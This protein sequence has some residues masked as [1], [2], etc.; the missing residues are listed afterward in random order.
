MR[1]MKPYQWC[2]LL[3]RGLALL[4][5]GSL[6]ACDI[7][8][9]NFWFLF[10]AP[11]GAEQPDCRTS[12]VTVAPGTCEMISNPCGGSWPNTGGFR[13]RDEPTGIWVKTIRTSPFGIIRTEREIC[14]T[15]DVAI[16]QNQP[17]NYLYTDLTQGV[18]LFGTGIIRITTGNSFSIAASATPPTINPGESSQLLATPSGGIPP[19][20]FVWLPVSTL[21]QIDIANPV[22]SPT[23]TTI[24]NV[25]ATDASGG[26]A[27]ASV[28]V[29][30]NLVLGA[31]ATPASITAGNSSQLQANVQ[32]G[33]LP[34]RYS[35]SPSTSLNDN[36]LA[37]PVATPGATTT[38]TVVVND[39]AG[40][41]ASASTTLTVTGGGPISCFTY[42]NNIPSQIIDLNASCSTGGVVR[43]EWDFSF[44]P[45]N[46]DLI[47]TP[48]IAQWEYGFGSTGTITLRVFDAGGAS[49]STALPF[50]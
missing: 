39:G 5:M 43:Y 11:P 3:R 37:N 41:N 22:A 15:A 23:I 25:T 13:L 48:P 6:T 9:L 32:G 45:G 40:G 30:V 8:I 18:R 31:T 14:A 16:V 42:T 49:A 33:T 34:Y 4:M 10:I 35:W 1:T 12:A 36:R 24:Y 38:Y 7:N 26:N 29:T 20:T 44:E 21:S 2:R 27:T 17:V 19:Y 46:P 50:P 28:T 47:R